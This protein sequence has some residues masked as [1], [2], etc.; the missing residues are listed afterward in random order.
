MVSL[1]D[2]DPLKNKEKDEDYSFMK[3]LYDMSDND[4]NSYLGITSKKPEKKSDKQPEKNQKPDK[5]PEKQP[6]KKPEKK[7]DS[8][9]NSEP[10]PELPIEQAES[11]DSSEHAITDNLDFCKKDLP[12][13]K[14]IYHVINFDKN[15]NYLFAGDYQKMFRKISEEKKEFWKD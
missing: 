15:I 2:Y 1:Y 4:L 12:K 10:R 13:K 3:K 11:S 14:I 8:S 7:P 5:Q 9:D 6:E